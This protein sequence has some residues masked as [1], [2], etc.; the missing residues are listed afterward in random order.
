MYCSLGYFKVVKKSGDKKNGIYNC[1]EEYNK[2]FFK[3]EATK[4]FS[5]VYL[6]KLFTVIGNCYIEIFL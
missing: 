1:S 5:L 4:F 3:T 6:C 2:L